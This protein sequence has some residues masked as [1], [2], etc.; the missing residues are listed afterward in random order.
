[1]WYFAYGSNMQSATFRGRR[2]IEFA[3]A[4][5]VRV[6]GWRLVFDKPS[7]L[8]FDEST[9]NIIPD[10]E[11][12]VLGVAYDIT[13]EDLAHIELTEGVLLGNY[14]RVTLAVQ[15]LTATRNAPTTAVS[16]S[17]DQRDPTL[18]PSNRYMDMVIAGALEHR[19]PAEHI[20]FLRGVPAQDESPEA[21]ALRPFI[22][23]AMRRRR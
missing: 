20:A 22:D 17:S 8:G 2:E 3:R 15:T 13:E 21:E 6:S 7:L 12:D 11:A 19:L 4:L 23:E 10:P 18:R 1:V 14:R 5:P 9:A 16:L